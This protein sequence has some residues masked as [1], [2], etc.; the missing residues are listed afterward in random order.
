MMV[1]KENGYSYNLKGF[2]RKVNTRA[3]I[4]ENIRT[5]EPNLLIKL[6]QVLSTW[7][8]PDLAKPHLNPRAISLLSWHCY[9]S[10][11]VFCYK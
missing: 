3:G 1:Q 8:G 7:T 4:K 6:S 5:L 10:F 2:K 11:L 9:F